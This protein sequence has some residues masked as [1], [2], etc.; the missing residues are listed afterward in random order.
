MSGKGGAAAPLVTALTPTVC[1]LFGVE[2]PA[3]SAREPLEEV[4]SAAR[5]DGAG[6]VAKCLIYAPDAI[7]ALFLEERRRLAERIRARARVEVTLESV[8]PTYTPVCFASMF[9]GALPEAHGIR[10]YEKPVVGID[11]IFDALVRAGKRIAIIAVADS[12]IDLIFRGRAVDQ[13]SEKYDPQVTERAIDLVRGGEHDL[14]LAY[15]QE[16]DDM[17][18]R[19]GP[20]SAVAVRAAESHVADFERLCDAAAEAWRK[21]PY[22]VV[23]APDHG[24]HSSENGRGTHGTDLAEDMLVRHFYGVRGLGR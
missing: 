11:T 10:K 2:P 22:A 24:A 3:Q 19:R 14:V 13:F 15:H 12:S 4:I 6:R 16:Y 17:M 9:T 8:S 5:R 23:F 21:H 20:N 7:G 1:A 18:H